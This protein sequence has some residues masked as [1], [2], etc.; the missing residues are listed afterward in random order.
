MHTEIW[1]LYF[2][3]H[4]GYHEIV[5]PKQRYRTIDRKKVTRLLDFEE[6][7]LGRQYQGWIKEALK[8]GNLRRMVSGV[9]NWL[10]MMMGSD[11]TVNNYL[12]L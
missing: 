1:D 2:D 3:R 5:K 10:L 12:F 4:S 11:I 7:E 9:V 8:Q 6:K